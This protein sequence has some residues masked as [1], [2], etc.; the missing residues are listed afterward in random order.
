MNKFI[1]LFF[2]ILLT[3]FFLFFPKSV[4]AN[5]PDAGHSSLTSTEVA[6]DGSATSTVTVTLQDSSATP[7]VG[8]TVTLSLP[9]DGTAVVNPSSNVLDA[10][11][12]ATFTVTS[13]TPGTDSVSVMDTT[14][15]ATLSALGTIIFDPVPTSSN[16]SAVQQTGGGSSTCAD[17]APAD[18]PGLFQVDRNQNSATLYFAQPTSQFDGYTISYGL[19]SSANDYSVSFSEGVLD[20]AV[21]YTISDLNVD[22]TYYFKVRA[23][24]GCAAGPWSTVLLVSQSGTNILPETGPGNSMLILGGF[25]AALVSVGI[26]LFLFI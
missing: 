15:V 21:K 22:T 14:Q 7:L 1:G 25:G 26:Y 18:A 2:I 8:D 6:A 3:S 17:Q 24:K 23:T 11:G 13:T 9:T 4:F 20:G 16:T 10:G 5:A 12:Q 19:N